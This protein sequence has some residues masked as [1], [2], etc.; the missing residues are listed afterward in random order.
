MTQKQADKAQRRA[1]RRVDRAIGELRR[2][3][4]VV[5]EAATDAGAVLAA[6]LVTDGWIAECADT[7]SAKP[8]LG[9]TARRANILHILPSGHDTQLVPIPD[10]FDAEMIRA[11]VDP[12]HDLDQPMRGPFEQVKGTPPTYASA[13]IDLCKA[14]KLLPAV[15]LIGLDRSTAAAWASRA[16]L[17]TVSDTAIAGYSEAAAAQL[18]RV[19][20]ANVPLA[21]SEKARLEVYRP[22]DGGVEHYAIIIGDPDRHQ[23]VLTRLHSECFTGDLL[24]SLKCDCGDQLRGA[25]QEIAAQGGGILLYLSQEG[26]GIGLAN[27]MRAYRLQDEGFDTI[28]ANERLGFE[29]DERLFAPA[30]EILRQLNVG[31]VRLMTNNPAKMSGLTRFGIDVVER[32]AHAFPSNPHNAHYLDTKKRRSGHHL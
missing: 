21:D 26:R 19:A 4:P 30:A 13:G 16:D 23:P 18:T 7:A 11:I 15:V 8:T 1:L 29:D 14:A 20:G 2:G 31:A 3:L 28:E 27:K 6:E 24:A 32:V 22:A 12:T 25:M 5:I 10:R 17:L 9:L